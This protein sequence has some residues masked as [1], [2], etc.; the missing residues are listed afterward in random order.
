MVIGGGDGGGGVRV[1]VK[2]SLASRF[3]FWFE[4]IFLALLANTPTFFLPVFR[5]KTYT[6]QEVTTPLSLR[7]RNMTNV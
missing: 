2:T 5:S 7:Q 4:S 1:T 3:F 6:D